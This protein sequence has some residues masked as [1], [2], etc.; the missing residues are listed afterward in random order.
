M[1]INNEQSTTNITQNKPNQTQF[2]T[3]KADV[4]RRN[5][6]PSLPYERL[7]RRPQGIPRLDEPEQI[8]PLA[9]LGGN[10]KWGETRRFTIVAVRFTIE[11]DP[12]LLSTDV[13]MLDT[14]GYLQYN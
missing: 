5:S 13:M 10:D 9:A 6:L 3:I 7:P 14:Y 8:P 1:S 11:A 4:K 12:K 2:Q